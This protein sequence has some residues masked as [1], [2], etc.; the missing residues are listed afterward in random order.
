[1]N[2]FLLFLSILTVSESHAHYSPD[3]EYNITTSILNGYNKDIQPANLTIRLVLTLNQIVAID[4]K[5][6]IMTTSSI[7][8]IIWNDT[9]LAFNPN[10]GLAEVLVPVSSIWLP[11]MYVVNTADTNGFFGYNSQN[12]ANISP[13]GMVSFLSKSLLFIIFS[14]I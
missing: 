10:L 4:E 1:M 5:N 11:D 12:L 7:I 9:R 2:L 14:S 13:G 3:E 6:Q 8:D